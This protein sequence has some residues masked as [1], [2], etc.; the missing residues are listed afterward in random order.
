VPLVADRRPYE[1]PV[2]RQRAAE[3][4]ERIVTAGSELA[5]ELSS[6]DW[7]DLT[8]RAVAERAG[9]GER[10]VYRHFPTERQLHDA[11]MQRLNEEAGADYD[12]VDLD[13]LGETTARILRSLSSFA[14]FTQGQT[15]DEPDDPTFHAVGAARQAA[16][17]RA[18]EAETPAWTSEQR[19]MAAAAL[20]A[21]WNLPTYE[22]MVGAWSLSP[23]AATA[24]TLWLI[25]QAITAIRSGTP[26]P[27][28]P[29]ASD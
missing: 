27:P 1:S 21:L 16:L 26:P 9:V 22:R 11:V 23:D 24:T 3:T 29:A 18:V 20:D 12:Q 19:E 17:R 5:H 6:W 8:F 13:N 2:R 15:V 28:L 7:K 10:T 25:D 4:R 14:S